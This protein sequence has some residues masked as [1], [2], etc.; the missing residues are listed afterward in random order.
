MISRSQQGLQ[1]FVEPVKDGVDLN[2]V[3]LMESYIS[4]KYTV[5]SIWESN[6]SGKFKILGKLDRER[7][8]CL[9]GKSKNHNYFLVEFLENGFKTVASTTSLS[10]GKV[11]NPFMSQSV[12]GGYLGLGYNKSSKHKDSQEYYTWKGML[13]RCYSLTEQERCPSYK[14]VLVSPRWFN[15]S[16]FCKDIKLLPNHDLWKADRGKYHLDKDML[17]DD[18]KIYSR[19][20]CH[21]VLAEDNRSES[22]IRGNL[23]GK[24]YK[25]IRVYDGFEYIT[26]IQ[27]DFGNKINVSASSIIHLIQNPL[28]YL[29][30]WTVEV[31]RNV[32]LSDKDLILE[33]IYNVPLYSG[34]R[35]SD[36]YEEEFTSQRAFSTSY[37]LDFKK[38]NACIKGH[39]KTCD[40][41]TFKDKG[42]KLIVES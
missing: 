38:V 42:V 1:D 6:T 39:R 11:L 23:T 28:K 29:K 8:L 17:S 30:G 21:F 37:S 41:W 36:S 15:F 16:T 32:E 26:D 34:I 13:G 9:E 27:K 2:T 35:L 18:F 20:T 3:V 7:S 19:Y 24:I 25:F 40:G 4:K 12:T 22:A 31:V 5:G 14:G 10:D 33:S